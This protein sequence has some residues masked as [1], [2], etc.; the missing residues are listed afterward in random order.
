[1]NKIIVIIKLSFLGCLFAVM[2]GCGSTPQLANGDQTAVPENPYL[3]NRQKVSREALSRFEKANAAIEK[4]Q[5]Q[6]AEGQLSWLLENYPQLSGPYL[7][8]ALVYRQTRQQ[9]KAADYFSK[10]IETNPTNLVAYNQYGIFLRE[11][12]EF[13]AAEAQYLKALAVWE[14]YPE[15]HRN[16]GV[17]NDLYLGNKKAALRHYYRYQELTLGKDRLVAAWI[18]DLERQLTTVA[19]GD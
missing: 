11:Q 1:M 15:T 7:D 10:A 9:E 12:G 13:Q 2:I 3:L 4:K 18:A 14:P 5:W 8:L 19:R 17:L 16:L 6:E